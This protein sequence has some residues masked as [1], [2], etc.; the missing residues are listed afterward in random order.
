MVRLSRAGARLR[1]YTSLMSDRRPIPSRQSGWAKRSAKLLAGA[2]VSPNQISIAST[3]VA[4][5][6]AA[7]L[8]ASRDAH[9]GARATLLLAA[10]LCIPLR[11]LCNLFD[12]MV[13]VEFGKGSKAGA[14][15]NELPD[16]LSDALLL[17]GAGYAAGRFDW[18]PELGWT[19][20]LLAILTAYIRTLGSASGATADF[21]GPFAKQQRMMLL[22]AACVVAAIEPLFVDEPGVVLMGA[23]VIIVAGTALTAIRRTRRLLHELESA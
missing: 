6:G 12:G 22:A 14:V 8:I 15:Y 2:G 23:L 9:D 19:A 21:S 20:A 18:A 13:A 16:R 17:V 11:L 3:A 5:V 10:A 7:C 1:P 4:A